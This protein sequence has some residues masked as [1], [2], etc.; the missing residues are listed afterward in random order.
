MKS[1]QDLDE[2]FNSLEENS[3]KNQMKIL[4]M[5]SCKS[6]KKKAQWKVSPIG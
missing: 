1:I 4:E 3:E 2:K 5:K 6:K